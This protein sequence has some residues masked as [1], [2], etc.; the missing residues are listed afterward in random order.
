VKNALARAG[1]CVPR[2]RHGTGHDWYAVTRVSIVHCLIYPA[3]TVCPTN[4]TCT[5]DTGLQHVACSSHVWALLAPLT[6]VTVTE[7]LVL[8]NGDIA[9]VTADVF[10]TAPTPIRFMS[11]SYN[12]ITYVSEDAFVNTPLLETLA[13]ASNPLTSLSTGVFASLVKLESLDLSNNELETLFVFPRLPV[14]SSIRLRG[15]SI[16]NITAAHFVEVQ[17]SLVFVSLSRTFVATNNTFPPDLLANFTGLQFL[18]LTSNEFGTKL[19]DNFLGGSLRTIG[20][21]SLGV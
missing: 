3:C 18:E 12:K 8:I 19:P 9:A 11:L 21:L 15:N 2:G 17:T 1:S 16:R 20:T 14:L 5:A 4:C 6:F 7:R 13:L 10:G